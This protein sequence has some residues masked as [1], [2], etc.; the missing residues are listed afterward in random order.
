MP[1]RLSMFILLALQ[2][3]AVNAL[4]RRAVSTGDGDDDVLVSIPL[5]NLGNQQYTVNVQMGDPGN[6]QDFA[7]SIANTYGYTAIASKCTTCTADGSAPRYNSSASKTYVP[8]SNATTSF[9]YYGKTVAGKLGT[10]NCALEKPDGTW[11]DYNGQTILVAGNTTNA[12]ALVAGSGILGLGQSGVPTAYYSVIGQYLKAEDSET[13]PKFVF[14]VALNGSSASDTSSATGSY[15]GV[16]HINGPDPSFYSGD[17]VTLPTSTSTDQASFNSVPDQLGSYDWTIK[18][19]GWSLSFTNGSSV[20]EVNGD[21][22]G[23]YATFESGY[24]YILLPQ[25]DAQK[26][27]AAIPNAQTYTLPANA[28]SASGVR[29]TQDPLAQSWFIPCGSISNASI[30]FNFSTVSVPVLSQ[31]LWVD[32]GNGVC[33]GNI[34]GWADPARTTAI[35]G[36]VF[37][38]GA[39]IVFTAFSDTQSNTIGIANRNPLFAAYTASSSKNTHRIIIGTVLGGLAFLAII[40]I[41]LGTY[42]RRRGKI[43]ARARVAP[44]AMFIQ[45]QHTAS[46]TP[47]S[48]FE[49]FYQPGQSDRGGVIGAGDSKSIFSGF[50]GRSRAVSMNS[51]HLSKGGQDASPQ[52]RGKDKDGYWVEPWTED[53]K[54]V[55][56]GRAKDGDVVVTPWVPKLP[57]EAVSLSPM[58]AL[59][60]STIQPTLAYH[61]PPPPA[62]PPRK[63][64]QDDVVQLP[65]SPP[66]RPAPTPALP[67]KESMMMTMP[68][69]QTQSAMSHQTAAPSY[70][71]HD[72]YS[73]PPQ[74]YPTSSYLPHD[75][76][77]SRRYS[78]PRLRASTQAI[79]TVPTTTTVASSSRIPT[80][81]F[82]NPVPPPA[83]IASIDPPK[84]FSDAFMPPSPTAPS[85]TGSTRTTARTIRPLPQAPRS[86]SVASSVRSTGI[87]PLPKIPPQKHETS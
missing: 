77:V 24:P 3:L 70:A 83:A 30:S 53:N 7:L 81:T 62:A 37:W 38:R 23:M 67:P 11:W 10:E 76:A 36:S 74:S 61:P 35:M 29:L 78:D 64:S 72:H 12:S 66:P 46:P 22:A 75:T 60:A 68:E 52:M 50:S 28:T 86:S 2:L 80:S 8:A 42:F 5:T 32:I 55:G 69:Q 57:S 54:S 18:M 82:V 79:A 47:P 85:L 19:T 43:L 14:A 33:V 51:K 6:T 20:S 1:S 44:S 49:P 87:R 40:L 58:T 21:Q 59:E 34:K 56:T 17:F 9:N 65:L 48:P 16:L 73:R 84:R 26:I 4:F 13:Y 31:D 63:Q 39:Y 25:A 45:S 27:Y 41:A 71:T 15:G